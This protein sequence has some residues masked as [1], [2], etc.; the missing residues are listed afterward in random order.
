MTKES[1]E[2]ASGDNAAPSAWQQAL[3]ELEWSLRQATRAVML[4]RDSLAA[5]GGEPAPATSTKPVPEPARAP[6]PQVELASATGAAN[7]DQ[8]TP[9]VQTPGTRETF[10]RLWDRIERERMERAAEPAQEGPQPLGRRGI[11]LLPKQYL[12]TVEDR[13]GSVDLVPLHRALLTMPGVEEISLI[14]YANGVP[15]ISVRTEGELDLELLGE[16]VGMSMD[17]LCEVI[18]QENGKVYLRMKAR[19]EQG[20]ID[21]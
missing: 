11:D 4:L 20:V 21:G 14:S 2:G 13:E 10:D 6:E 16:N 15:V 1:L 19:E 8:S 17:R 9:P 12:M 5:D 18:P 3:E 7:D